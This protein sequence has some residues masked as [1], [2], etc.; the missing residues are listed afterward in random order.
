M[1]SIEEMNP[2]RPYDAYTVPITRRDPG[3]DGV[4]NNSDDGGAHH[5]V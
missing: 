3:P 4:L 1:A 5:L 2:K